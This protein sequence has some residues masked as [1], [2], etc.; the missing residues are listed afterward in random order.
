MH[1]E[2]ESFFDR[3]SSF[4]NALEEQITKPKS[5]E[6]IEEVKEEKSSTE[7][8][9]DAMSKYTKGAPET[10]TAVSYTHLRAHET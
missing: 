6:V 2:L 1:L 3:L 8:L 10:I 4:E 9:A 7:L 5:E